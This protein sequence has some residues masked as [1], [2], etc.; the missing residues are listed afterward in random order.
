MSGSIRPY[1]LLLTKE[2]KQVL[3]EAADRLLNCIYEGVPDELSA[4]LTRAAYKIRA[5]LAAIAPQP[6][7]EE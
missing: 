3:A 4:I 2:E 6:D 7:E 5:H 1:R